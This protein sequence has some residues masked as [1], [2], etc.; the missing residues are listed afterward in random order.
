M[1]TEDLQLLQDSSHYI[2]CQENY[3]LIKSF[4]AKNT[5]ISETRGNMYQKPQKSQHT[6]TTCNCLHIYQKERIL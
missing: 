6:E 2:I 5:C 3:L 4:M 1:D